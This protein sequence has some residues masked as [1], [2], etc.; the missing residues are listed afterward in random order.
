MPICIEIG[1]F[2]FIAR[3]HTD[4]RYLYSK[5]VC[6]SV[7]L[8]VRDVPVS[9]ENGLTYCHSFFYHTVAQSL[10]FYQNQTSS[11]NSD[12]VTRC[13]GAKYRWGIK[14]SLSRYISQMM[15]DIAIVSMEGE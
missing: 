14:I 1:S 12:G 6:P 2:V 15:Q 10:C 13:V 4:A 9:D 11:R 5:Y 8:S 3:Q 7:R